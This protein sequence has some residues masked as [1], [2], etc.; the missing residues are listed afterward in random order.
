MNSWVYVLEEEEEEEEEKE[1]CVRASH[2]CSLTFSFSSP[3]PK[4]GSS[5]N[6]HSAGFMD[7]G[8]EEGKSTHRSGRGF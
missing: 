8:G 6:N 5:C 7:G 2:Y 1:S 3:N 4:L